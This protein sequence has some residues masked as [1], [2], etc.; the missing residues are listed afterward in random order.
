MRIRFCFRSCF[1]RTGEKLLSREFYSDGTV[2]EYPVFVSNHFLRIPRYYT[3]NIR[4]YELQRTIAIELSAISYT[5]LF[6]R[7]V[8]EIRD[9]FASAIRR[10]EIRAKLQT[11]SAAFR[12]YYDSLE[13]LNQAW[14]ARRTCI[15]TVYRFTFLISVRKFQADS[16]CS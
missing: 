11:N 3:T 14:G 9:K 13:T 7:L 5:L 16:I 12:G 6:P 1:F 15:E 8:R 10:Q 4:A 2:S